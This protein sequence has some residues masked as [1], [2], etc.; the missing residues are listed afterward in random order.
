MSS[1]AVKQECGRAQNA[2]RKSMG[3]SFHLHRYGPL[4]LVAVVDE[5][6]CAGCCARITHAAA[7]ARR[8]WATSSPRGRFAPSTR[9]GCR[10]A[11]RS[12]GGTPLAACG[13]GR[14]RGYEG[15]VLLQRLER[16]D[17]DTIGHPQARRQL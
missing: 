3:T 4:A 11:G 2:A 1:Y 16:P 14:R 7:D 5:A 15:P 17:P 8:G 10:R 13:C 9:C 6:G 12:G